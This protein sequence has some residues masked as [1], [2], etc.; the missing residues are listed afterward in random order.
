[1]KNQLKTIVCFLIPLLINSCDLLQNSKE[2]SYWGLGMLMTLLDS[3]SNERLLGDDESFI[4]HLDSIKLYD[5][6]WEEA[7]FEG[8]PMS[9]YWA[10]LSEVISGKCDIG[11]YVLEFGSGR[12]GLFDETYYLRLTYDEIDTLRLYHIE[13]EPNNE[14]RPY[15]RVFEYNGKLVFQDGVD[16]EEHSLDITCGA[17][18]PIFK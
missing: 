5:K 1:M 6:N 2:E 8:L 17:A 14:G 3:T 4:Y 9:I 12:E 7:I 10:D 15:D 11:Y 13:A 18:V 16:I